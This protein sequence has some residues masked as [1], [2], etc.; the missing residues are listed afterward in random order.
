MFYANEK[1]MENMIEM[2]F[3]QGITACLE[4]LETL[5]LENKI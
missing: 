5:F 1:K 3:E 4:Q 2:G